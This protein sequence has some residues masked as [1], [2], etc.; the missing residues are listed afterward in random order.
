MVKFVL[1]HQL[2]GTD[3]ENLIVRAARLL[4]DRAILMGT[5]PQGAGADISVEKQL[6]MGG[7]WV[8]VRQTRQQFWWR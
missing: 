8:A 5:L 2:K 7:V 4:Q 6:P 1:R 3:E